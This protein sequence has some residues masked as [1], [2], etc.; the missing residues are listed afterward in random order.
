MNYCL[1]CGNPVKNKYCDVSC[2]NKHLGTERENKKYGELKSFN[3][4]CNK[5]GKEFE[6]QE[7]EKFFPMKD[8]YYCSRSCANSHVRTEGSKQKTS[9]KM[10]DYHFGNAIESNKEI[11]NCIECNKEILITPYYLGKKHFCSNKCR[12]QYDFK[13]K[14]EKEKYRTLAQ[15]KFSLNQFPN[16]F[17]FSLIKQHGWYQAKNHGNNLNGVSRD[18]MLSIDEGVKLNI[19]PLLLAHPA[20]CQLLCHSDNQ[21]KQHKS[22]ITLEQL[23]EKIKIWEFKYGVY[24]K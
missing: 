17:D 12:R 6:I 9:S 5:C 16:E 1:Y 14:T 8:K 24:Y 10:K 2:Q 13:K 7:R 23:L 18:H 4:L 20:N 22:S 3:V 21:I 19:D 15:F 11:I